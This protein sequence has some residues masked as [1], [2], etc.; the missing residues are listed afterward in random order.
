MAL[1]MMTQSE[2]A[3]EL[4]D[5]T[6]WNRADAKRALAE[7]EGI[8]RDNLGQC[9]RTKVAGVVIEPKL[10]KATKKRMGRNPQTGEAVEISAKPASVRVAAR[11]SKS[12]KESAP[13][14][15]KLQNNL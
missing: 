5:R 4:A 14:T 15:K 1:P 12:L 3:A 8:V 10:R 7:L 2:L 6:G 9:I 11:V 13:T